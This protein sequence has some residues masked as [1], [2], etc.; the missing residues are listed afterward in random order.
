[1]L[2][3]LLKVGLLDGIEKD[4]YAENSGKPKPLPSDYTYQL[5]SKPE[6]LAPDPGSQPILAPG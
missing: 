1:V 2:Q 4:D 6:R 3:E 5:S